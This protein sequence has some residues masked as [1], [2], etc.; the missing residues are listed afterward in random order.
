LGIHPAHP[1]PVA[2]GL[3][4]SGS[5]WPGLWSAP[6]RIGGDGYLVKRPE[7]FFDPAGGM[8]EDVMLHLTGPWEP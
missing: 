7:H 4:G 2:A 8:P 5:A 1:N 3:V 6:E